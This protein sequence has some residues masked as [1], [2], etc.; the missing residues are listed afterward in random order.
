TWT[1]EEAL[2]ELL[3]GRMTI[4]GPVTAE[5]IARSL[6]IATS[7]VEAAMLTLESEGLVLRGSFNPGAGTE[8]CDRTLLARIHRY[9]LNRLRA[10]I[11]PVNIAELMRFLFSWQHVTQKLTGPDGLRALANQLAGYEAPAA[12][13]ERSILPARMDRYDASMLDALCLSGELGWAKGIVFFPR[14]DADAWLSG[15]PAPSPA[16]SEQATE[17]LNALKANG[18][19]FLKDSDALREL[20]AAG[21]ITSDS[22]AGARGTGSPGRWSILS[23][24]PPSAAAL[25]TQAMTLLQRYGVIFRRLLTREP[26]TPPWRELVRIYRRLEARGEIRGGRFVNG[27]SGEQFALP[28]AVERLRE[29]RRSG[30]DGQIITI[31]ASDPLNLTGILTNG[32]RVRAIAATRIAWRDGI[33]ISAMEGDYL[34]P[35]VEIDE[36]VA[37]E[38]ASML[39]GRRVPVA[40]GFVGRSA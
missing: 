19:S 24:A 7:E 31:S 38:A 22:F 33:A 8:W 23:V 10:E 15:A 18:A 3:R 29:T 12:A 40:S 32:E 2:I 25:E 11:E 26:N 9:T 20:I 4:L 17:I 28:R 13:W 14:S 16:L 21:L 6:A 1:R 5:E 35:L 37:F 30:R 36:T 27:V 39:A 34:R